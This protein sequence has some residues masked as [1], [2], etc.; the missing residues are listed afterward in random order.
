MQAIEHAESTYYKKWSAN[1]KEKIRAYRK[2]PRAQEL[3][4]EAS[5]R[6]RKNN[7][8]AVMLRNAK[9]SAKKR[10]LAFDLELSDIV[11]PEVCPALGIPLFK[12]GARGPNTPSLDRIVPSLGY[13][14]GNVVVVS[15]L[16]N[17]I[18]TDATT[19]QILAVGAFYKKFGV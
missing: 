8:E 11:I 5:A 4:K 14:K 6:Y 16:A 15:L 18:K 10:G 19:E 17:R 12:N 3:N 7:P 9:Q 2:K 13:T 1:N